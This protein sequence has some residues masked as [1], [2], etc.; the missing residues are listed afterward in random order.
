MDT[1]KRVLVAGAGGFIG[2]HLV[3]YLKKKG[4][5]IRGAD[6]KYPEYEKTSADEFLLLDLRTKE[7]TLQATRDINHVYNLASNMGGVGFMEIVHAELMHDNILIDVNL[8]EASYRNGVKNF[9]YPSSA[10][11]YPNF[12][13]NAEL[14][15]EDAYP[16]QPGSEYGWQKLFTERLCQDYYTDYGFETRVARFHNIYGP[17]GVY[18]GGREKSPAALCRK[19]ALAKD[20]EEIEVWG[21]GKQLRSYCY[22]ND[23]IVGIYKLMQSDI[24]QPINIG[25]NRAVS[26]NEFIDILSA[27]AGKKVKKR[28]DLT[29]PQGVRSRN[30]DN[31]LIR[32]LLNW[33]PSTLLEDGLRETYSWIKKQVDKNYS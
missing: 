4:Y 31:T 9:F 28:Y 33:E 13:K 1:K 5:W 16:A 32:K 2:H 29:K 18:D 22:V 27:I 14:R 21:D 24:H 25:S 12:T 20:G 15:E 23:C 11:V 7:A 10:L 26:I 30:S 6:I 19:I 3:K 8:L 17:L